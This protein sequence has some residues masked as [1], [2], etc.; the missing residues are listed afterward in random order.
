MK[1]GTKW[2]L[3]NLGIKLST[4]R[5]YED[6]GLMDEKRLG[7]TRKPG[8][9]VREYNREQVEHIWAIKILCGIGF[10]YEEL[11]ELANDPNLN[12]NKYI[13]E[14]VMALEKKQEEVQQNLEYAKTIQITGRIPSLNLFDRESKVNADDF[15]Q[16]SKEKWNIFSDPDIAPMAEFQDF[17]LNTPKET[18]GEELIRK[19]LEAVEI[20]SQQWYVVSIVSYFQILVRLS[21]L[22]YKSEIIQT[23]VD[24]L[25]LTVEPLYPT[26]I[27]PLDFVQ[28]QVEQLLDDQYLNYKHFPRSDREFLAN[29]LCY[30]TKI[31]ADEFK[32]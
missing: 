18:W 14:K 7:P 21:H 6:M 11:Q 19:F 13:G 17:I 3:E 26:P 5:H 9:D 28:A 22:D 15:I 25:Y 8:S 16:E 27:S 10:S 24:Q 1:Y 31:D 12:F 23:I 32:L 29:A 4:I 2:I 20:L 30:Y